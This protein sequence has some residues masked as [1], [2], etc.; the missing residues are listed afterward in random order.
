[1]I[2]VHQ[3]APAVSPGTI[4]S[5]R[6]R[7]L[8]T[9]VLVGL[10]TSLVA[11]RATPVVLFLVTIPIVTLALM[12]T[13]RLVLPSPSPLAMALGALAGYLAMNAL[14][15]VNPWHGLSRAMLC[16]LIIVVGMVVA[17]ALPKISSEH[18]TRLSEALLIG[19]SLAAAYLAI[20][21]VAGQ[22]IRRFVISVLP[23]LQ[24]SSKHMTTADG[25]V[26]QLNLYTLNRNLGLLNLVLWPTLL[27]AR[28]YFSMSLARIVGLG[29]LS[30][31]ALGMF[32]SEH[33]SSMLALAAGCLVFV[34]MTFAASTM[35]RIVLAVWIAATLLVVPI[36]D[37]A[38]DAG[39]H[40]AG[41]LPQTARNR[42]ILWSVTADR[43]QQAPI[44]GIGIDST[45]PLDEESA[46]SAPRNPGDAYAQRT[47]RHAHNI[48]M[49]TWYEL[50]A[51]GAC[52]LLIVG[53]VALRELSRLPGI[54]QPFAYAGF[55]SALA[56]ASFTWGMWQPWFMC[57]FGL[58]AVLWLIALDAARR[59]HRQT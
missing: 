13:R 17:A 1:M 42:I 20:E 28:T 55:V 24:P 48:F 11:P 37:I 18:A 21:I 15:A 5:G 54:Q 34:G 51:V 56:I 43:L 50:G 16:G 49:Q 26:A 33:E 10:V 3:D 27:V 46:A 57:A 58:W 8:A 31:A 19:V 52:L 44:L 25:W 36:A 2:N 9:V 41:W 59:E 23:V 7:I 32:S 22:P 53:I 38:H 4:P 12:A 40:Q 39:L 6:A 35:R 14:W 29:L 47:G 30:V 45:K